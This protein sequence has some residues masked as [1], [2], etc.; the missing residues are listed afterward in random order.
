MAIAPAADARISTSSAHP[1]RKP[2]SRPQPS[3]RNTYHPPVLGKAAASS[4][5]DSAPHREI[6]PPRSHTPSIISGSGTRPAITAGVRK[7][8][9]PIVTP[10]TRPIDDQKPSR[11]ERPV[12]CA[13]L[14]CMSTIG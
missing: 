9:D 4:A 11:R 5:T 3:R 2:A 8:P 7:I 12:S 1:N 13:E 10:I 6:N 14:T